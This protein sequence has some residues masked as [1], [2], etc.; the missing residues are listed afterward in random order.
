ME[1]MELTE[2][3]VVGESQK[4]QPTGYLPVPIILSP[5]LLDPR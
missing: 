1:L 5:K 3:S 4:L 2:L